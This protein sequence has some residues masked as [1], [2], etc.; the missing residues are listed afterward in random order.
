MSNDEEVSLK[1][2]EHHV[3]DNGH[4]HAYEALKNMNETQRE[5]VF[6][7]ARHSP[8]G[9]FFTARK[10]GVDHQF[11]ISSNGTIHKVSH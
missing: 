10:D 8:E 5:Q 4:T 1:M 3:K 11:R 7:A 2:G 6:H 9:G